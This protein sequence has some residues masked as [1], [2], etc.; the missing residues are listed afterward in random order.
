MSIGIDGLASGLDTTALI[1]SLMQLEA[2][3]QHRLKNKVSAGKAF[4]AALQS[5]NSKVAVLGE[6]AGRVAKPDAF[7]V[8]RA[9]SDAGSVTAT[10]GG[11]ASAGRLE[12]TVDRLAQRQVVVTAK[13]QVWPSNPPVLTFVDANGIHTEIAADSDSLDDVVQ[14]VNDSGAGV[15]AM[16]VA[17]GTDQVTGEPMYRLQ[18][19]AAESG[20][21]SAFSA[22]L[23]TSAE[24][25]AGTA[26]DLLASGATL[27]RS[28]QDAQVTIW[29]GSAAAQTLTSASDTFTD[30][31]PGVDVTVTETSTTP[32]SVT[33]ARDDARIGQL[34]GELATALDSV[35]S[36]IRA[37]TSV[38]TA[39]SATGGQVE[40]SVF[41]GDNMVRNLNQQIVSAAVA[42]VAGRSPAEIG[43]GITR[44]GTIEFDDDKFQQV[45]I[46]EPEFAQSA[47][48][49]LA[50]RIAAVATEASDKHQGTITAR[51]AGQET[52]IDTLSDQV[53][54]WDR[55]LELRRAG[56]ERTY[57]ALEVQLSSLQAQSA[58]LSSQIES[59]PTR[60]RA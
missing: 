59:I 33:I 39:S 29:A 58:W 20:A 49:E 21:A 16:K 60:E 13:M 26:S 30:L 34:A 32:V 23:G 6:K 5:L 42:P 10:A 12:F 37:A 24:V 56:L 22:Y 47:L 3:P 11:S 28:A 18:L 35:L 40:G 44:D 19:T 27:V 51:I 38:D 54:E 7:A 50:G 4:V 45:L 43:I 57:A 36:Y 8:F 17:S 2:I 52:L 9:T 25:T 1:N 46:Q 41:T 55:R 48:R 31:M 15:T 53:V 14:A